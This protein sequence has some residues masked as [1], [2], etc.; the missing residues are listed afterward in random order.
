MRESG[1]IDPYAI[2][3]AEL[4]ELGDGLGAQ[5]LPVRGARAF[6]VTGATPNLKVLVQELAL[7]EVGVV[8][9]GVGTFDAMRALLGAELASPLGSLSFPD[10]PA[11]TSIV[12]EPTATG[13]TVGIDVWH[14]TFGTLGLA[15]V[16]PSV[17][18]A[19]LAGVVPHAVERALIEGDPGSDVGPFLTPVSVGAVFDAAAAQ[20]IPTRLLAGSVP[21][22]ISYDPESER[23]LRQGLDAG[24]LVIV[25]E[26]A[27]DL[28]GRPRLGWWLVDPISGAA[29]DQMDDGS[30][31]GQVEN[32]L[33][34]RLI[35]FALLVV[36]AYALQK[37]APWLLCKMGLNA[38]AINETS[39]RRL[40]GE[41]T[42]S[43][44]CGAQTGENPSRRM[45]PMQDPSKPVPEKRYGPSGPP[46]PIPQSKKP[47]RSRS[48]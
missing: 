39:V 9:M 5:Y 43:D 44:S 40:Q 1:A 48:K 15:D 34:E 42:G 3:A 4:V 2:P 16:A 10:A 30:G 31:Q 32:K 23:L 36:A 33:V 26:R 6:S 19:L 12:A 24:Q 46:E 7:D 37:Y 14:R 8:S 22:G 35:V 27:V 47:T 29:V 11:V 41:E 17:S 45:E 18:P 13:A 38:R 25:P 21:T 20:G 28:G